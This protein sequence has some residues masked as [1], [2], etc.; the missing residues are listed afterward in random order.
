MLMESVVI[1]LALLMV[2]VV[3]MMLRRDNDYWNWGVMKHIITAATKEG[4]SDHSKTATSHN[5]H[6]CMSSTKLCTNGFSR[7][8]MHKFKLV[9]FKL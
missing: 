4:A 5:Y 1:L 3:R 7:R 2:G 6:I 8:A 9:G